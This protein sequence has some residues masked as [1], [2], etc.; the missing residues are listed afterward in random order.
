MR[1]YLGN[2]GQRLMTRQEA[3]SIGSHVYLKKNDPSKQQKGDIPKLDPT[4]C[5]TAD[6]DSSTSSSSASSSWIKLETIN[7]M[8]ASFRDGMMCKNT[9]HGLFTRAK[10][11][12]RIRVTLIDQVLL[13]P[14]PTKNDDGKAEGGGAG[15]SEYYD[16][17][18]DFPCMIPTIPCEQ[19][20]LQML[21]IIYDMI[22]NPNHYPT[23]KM[24]Y[25]LNYNPCGRQDLVLVE[26]EESNI[27]IRAFT[28]GY[29]MYAPSR[30]IVYHYYKNNNKKDKKDNNIQMT[31]KKRR[32]KFWD[33]PTYDD[34]VAL[35]AMQRLN[36]I[37]E[38]GINDNDGH[39][40]PKSLKEYGIGQVRTTEKYYKTFGF[41]R[42]NKTMEPNL[43][44][45]VASKE[46]NLQ[47][48]PALRDDTMGL[49]YNHENLKDWEFKDI[50]PCPD[51]WWLD[52]SCPT[53]SKDNNKGESTDDEKE[54]EEEEGSSKE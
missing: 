15:A 47:F 17:V 36:A 7:V 24:I 18:D 53:S 34:E 39:V 49:D 6:V 23:F 14:N 30:P 48:L 45:F 35:E 46:M 37:I 32:L 3:L 20:P 9:L 28:Y 22:K 44:M 21:D 2:Y 4:A 8:I 42:E 54:E 12:Q 27:G 52:D 19:D 38:L 33:L 50:W 51:Y 43:C 10:Y 26:G 13:E 41:H 1:E 29:D 16:K 40:F 5:G 31:K 25:N 11:P